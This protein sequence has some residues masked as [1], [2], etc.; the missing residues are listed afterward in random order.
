MSI[1]GRVAD[2]FEEIVASTAT[3]VVILSVGWGVVTRYITA[4]PAAWASEVATLGFAWV[5]FFGAA[6]CVKYHLHP[7][8]D[9]LTRRLPSAGQRL[10]R[11][12]NHVLLF[13]FYGFMVWFGTRFAVD[14]WDSPTA[15]L[16]LPQTVL[17]GPVALSFYRGAWCPFCRTELTALRDAHRDVIEAGGQIVSIAAEVGGRAMNA[18]QK[19]GLPF[20]DLCDVDLGVSLA[21]GLVFAITEE[22]REIYGRL[23]YDLEAFNGNDSWFLPVPAT[24]VVAPDGVVAAA[25]IEPDFRYRMEPADIVNAIKAINSRRS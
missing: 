16:R 21:F 12:F 14:A 19:H 7:A 3:A 8:I 13:A 10:V 1:A 15:V 17:Y 5:V 20:E 6:A 4:Q 25:F 18:M 11:G 2:Q 22:V 9:L 24:Y 23:G